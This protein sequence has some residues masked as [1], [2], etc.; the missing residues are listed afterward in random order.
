MGCPLFKKM[1][2]FQAHTLLRTTVSVLEIVFVGQCEVF[3]CL[4]FVLTFFFFCLGRE[5]H[6]SANWMSTLK[7]VDIS[8]TSPLKHDFGI[9]SVIRVLTHGVRVGRLWSK[10]ILVSSK[11][12]MRSMARKLGKI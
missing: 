7:N 12:P 1:S 3:V 5:T 9:Y 4:D 2:I 10:Q 8:D 11:S 6:R